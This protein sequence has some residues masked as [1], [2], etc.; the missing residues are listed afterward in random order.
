MAGRSIIS[1]P[2]GMMPAAMTAATQ[3]PALS[4]VR[5]ADQA[6][7]ASLGL[8]QDADGHFGDDAEQAFRA[9][10]HAEQVEPAPFEWLAAQPDDLAVHQHQFDAQDIVGGQAVF[11]AVHPAGVLRHIAADGAGDL[12]GRIGRVVEAV[13]FHRLGDREVGDARLHHGDAVVVVDLEDAVELR[14]AEQDAVGQRQRAARQR[15]AGA[16]RHDLHFVGAAVGEDL[17]RPG[18]WSP[19][20]RTSMRRLAIG[21]QAVGFVGGHEAASS[22]TPSGTIR[23]QGGR[24]LVR[25]ARGL[26]GRA[27]A[28]LAASLPLLS[29]TPISRAGIGLEG[30]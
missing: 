28:W 24:D 12:A 11:Q 23:R 14:H 19:A 25:G 16:A 5:E 3:L 6:A 9:D 2:A 17:P 13:A 18:R 15:G 8:G 1:M 20:A 7:R 27:L 10:D 29:A 30:S 4:T 26:R 21:G 22:I